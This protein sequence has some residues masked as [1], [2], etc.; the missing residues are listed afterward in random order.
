M[1]KQESHETIMRLKAENIDLMQKINFGPKDN[2]ELIESK[3]RLSKI[4]EELQESKIREN[5][6]A[7]KLKT[8]EEAKEKL[9]KKAEKY[10]K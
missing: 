8:A 4:Q 10:K 1:T 2:E 9:L 7:K 5:Q 6:L 3:L